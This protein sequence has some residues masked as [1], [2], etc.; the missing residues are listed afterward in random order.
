MGD[1]IS[2][3]GLLSPF[4]QRQRIKAAAPFLAGRVLDIGS[5][6]GALAQYVEPSL[7]YGFEPDEASVANARLKFPRHTF[8]D[9][10]PNDI[11]DTV[12]AL[13]V[14]EHLPSPSHAVAEW[15]GYLRAGG[16]LV[17]TTP[18][19]AFDRLHRFCAQIGLASKEGAAQHEVLFDREALLECA[20]N[21]PLTIDLYRRF[22]FGMNQLF[23]FIRR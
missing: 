10:M 19:R 16:R 4:L 6:N 8:S 20:S 22:L 21:A 15:A 11:F 18:H 23:I 7:Y 3:G 17:L 9:K 12:L 2:G 1:Q 13:A 14:I 5:A